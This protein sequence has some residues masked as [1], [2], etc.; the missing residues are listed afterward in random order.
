MATS[1]VPLAESRAEQADDHRHDA[2][3]V[4][5]GDH[6]QPG[7][8]ERAP[9]AARS[10]RAEAGHD[11]P[12][13]GSEITDPAAIDSSTRPSWA[14]VEAEMGLDLRD[15]RRPAR[16]R[17]PGAD[18]RHVD[19]QR[20]AAELAGGR[21]AQGP[22]SVDAVTSARR[23]SRKRRSASEPASSSASPVGGRGLGRAARAGAAGRRA[24]RAAG[25]SRP[26]R[27]RPRAGRRAPARRRAR[28][29]RDGDRTVERDDRRRASARARSSYSAAISAQSV[30]AASPRSAWQAA[31]A[32]CS[33]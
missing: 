8:A 20:G 23:R 1:Q 15:P 12:A 28:G 5:H 27:P 6:H 11:G 30:S 3:A 32:A 22:G 29:H 33:W 10:P 18:E 16:K 25:G 7:A 17:E 26:A 19:G 13:S 4:A 31:I 14:G 9:S 2:D 21:D 24:W